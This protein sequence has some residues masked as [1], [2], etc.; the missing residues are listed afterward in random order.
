MSK[1]T[2]EQFQDYLKKIREMA[3]GPFEK[4]NQKWS[5]PTGFLSVFLT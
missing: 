4:W 1:F 2:P 3:E 5:R